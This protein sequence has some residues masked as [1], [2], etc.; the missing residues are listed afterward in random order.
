M[1]LC[2]GLRELKLTDAEGDLAHLCGFSSLTS[3]NLTVNAMTNVEALSSLTDL[4][5]LSFTVDAFDEMDGVVHPGFLS[6]LSCLTS[7]VWGC[8]FEAAWPAPRLP[9]LSRLA[10]QYDPVRGGTLAQIAQHMPALTHLE[11]GR[12][13]SAELELAPSD[14]LAVLPHVVELVVAGKVSLQAGLE[15]SAVD[16]K[17]MLPA[18]PHDARACLEGKL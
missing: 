2:A 10:L 5:V 8:G 16:I 3:L 1:R 7:L 13:G 17:K 11:F 14:A 15:P 4:Q 9:E 12:F 18:L 6:H